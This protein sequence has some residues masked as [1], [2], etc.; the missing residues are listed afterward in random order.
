MKKIFISTITVIGYCLLITGCSDEFL[1]EKKLYGKYSEATVYNNYETAQNR[2]DNLYFQLLPG[3]NEGDGIY[4]PI[5]S[6]GGADDDNCS[7][8]EYSGVSA[9]EDN[10]SLL[11]YMVLNDKKWDHIYVEFKENSPYGQI[12]NINDAIYGLENHSTLKENERNEL[13]GQA[14][15]MRAWRYY[16]MVRWHGGVPIIK[17]VEDALFSHSKDGSLIHHRPTTKECIDFICE[18]LDKAAQMLPAKWERQGT[19]WGRVTA[20]TA[21]ALKGRVLLLWASPLFNR[22]DDA[23]R[24]QAAYEANKA[25]LAKLDEGGFGLAYEG[26]PG[27][28]ATSAANWGKIFL[29]TQGTDGTV[30]EAVFVTLYNNL[31]KQ[32]D[33]SEKNNGWEQRIRPKTASGGG[34]LSATSEIVDLFPM[35]DGKKPGA[36]EVYTY[37][38]RT[39]FQNRDPRFYRTFAFPGVKWAYEGNTK[40]LLTAT[41]GDLV[42]PNITLKDG[43][44]YNGSDYVLWSYAWYADGTK[45]TSETSSG[46]YADALADTRRTV[47]VRKRS[48]DTQLNNSP[49]YVYTDNNGNCSFSQSGAPYMEMRYAEV[50]LNFA[51]AA[52]ATDRGD[53]ALT[54]LKRIRSRVY[55]PATNANIDANYGLVNGNRAQNSAQVLYER[56]IELAY[57]GKRFEDMRRWMLF[58]GGVGQET[59]SPTWKVTGFG[60]N[61]CQYL[62]VTPANSHGKNHIIELYATQL[63]T[64]AENNGADPILAAGVDRPAPLNLM[65]RTEAAEQQLADFYNANLERKD[66]LEDNNTDKVPTFQKNYYFLG[67][68]YSAMYNAAALVQTIGWEDYSHGGDGKYDPVETDPA[69]IVVDT[70]YSK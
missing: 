41:K 13:L 52:A 21:L 67:L 40:D 34:G 25:A 24:W 39:F 4:Q 66:R 3:Q 14:Y 65:Q 12:R 32:E 54:A 46:W 49:L 27:A 53:E 47:Y 70:N 42:Y 37:D 28:T 17:E 19:N 58:D 11:D 15:F 48:D 22:A 26:N 51:E 16:T 10:T 30:N 44:P 23:A 20:G 50:L 45:Q 1:E 60:G 7:T 35:A 38:R 9:W 64:D 2:I 8:E 31:S 61:T 29:N 55:D 57:E 43:Y 59:L 68:C 63:A 69:K 62:G 5:V 36:S 56:Q 6:T 18:D 33:N